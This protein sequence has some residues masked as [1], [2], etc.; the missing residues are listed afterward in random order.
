MLAQSPVI[1]STRDRIL[2]SLRLT[3]RWRHFNVTQRL[4]HCALYEPNVLAPTEFQNVILG[5]CAL[6]MQK[7]ACCVCVHVCVCVCG[8]TVCEVVQT[9]HMSPK[10]TFRGPTTLYSPSK[11]SLTCLT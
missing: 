9:Y 4:D 1:G 6:Y 10:I 11:S 8:C 2:A 5:V 7:D 3:D